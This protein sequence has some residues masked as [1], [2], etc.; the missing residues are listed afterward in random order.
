MLPRVRDD[1]LLE[2]R[3]QLEIELLGYL[4]RPIFICNEW[5][6]HT[7][8][9]RAR[10]PTRAREDQAAF[11]A[12]CYNNGISNSKERTGSVC[13]TTPQSPSACREGAGLPSGTVQRESVNSAHVMLTAGRPK[14]RESP[15]TDSDSS[16]STHTRGALEHRG[17][18]TE[19]ELSL[20][21]MA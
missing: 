9:A 17:E 12:S 3:I 2:F 14:E 15:S 7:H 16:I 10:T 5:T 13:G 1:Q 20:S 11:S 19:R 8:A 4:V 18:A 21:R 6:T